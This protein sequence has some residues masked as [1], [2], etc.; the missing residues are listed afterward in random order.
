MNKLYSMQE[1][2][3][4]FFLHTQVISMNIQSREYY[5]SLPI[6]CIKD[7][8]QMKP[9]LAFIHLIPVSYRNK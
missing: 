5:S 9:Y 7:M 2:F 4:F 1:K 8:V 6:D 3:V